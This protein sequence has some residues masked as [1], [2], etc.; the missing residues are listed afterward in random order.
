[1]P[2]E[3]RTEKKEIELIETLK[4]SDS[5]SEVIEKLKKIISQHVQEG[6]KEFI[7]SVDVKVYR[8]P[9]RVNKMVFRAVADEYVRGGTLYEIWKF[10]HQYYAHSS[11]FDK[12]LEYKGWESYVSREVLKLIDM[13]FAM[14]N[15]YN[16]LHELVRMRK[17]LK[18]FKDLWSR[19]SSKI[20]VKPNPEAIRR[21][22]QSRPSKKKIEVK[23]TNGEAIVKG[24]Y[25]R[26]LRIKL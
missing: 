19:Y 16:L 20:V 14:T 23:I 2:S 5:P 21:L 25:G 7:L 1:M 6:K 12:S 26:R 24:L 9:K 3:E 4:L 17:K 15:K 11:K 22:L 13:G 8:P 10:V 18:R